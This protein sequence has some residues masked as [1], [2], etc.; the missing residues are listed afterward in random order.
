MTVVTAKTADRSPTKEAV[1][2]PL[3][4][5]LRRVNQ[6]YRS[7]MAMQLAEAG[8]GDLPQRGYWVLMAIHRG[9][10]EASQLV[11]EMAISK[12]AVSKVVE[13]LVA[14]SYLERGPNAADR[15]RTDLLL[16]AKGRKAVGVIAA[17]VAATEETLIAEL[18]SESFLQLRQMLEQL[19]LGKP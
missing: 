12:Q 15:R 3:P 16:T 4:W 17:A 5:L 19:A 10:R 8:L 9:V 7:G 13:T 14:S 18:G 1:S 2:L 11:P 6:R